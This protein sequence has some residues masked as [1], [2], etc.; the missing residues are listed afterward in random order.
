M[1]G[2][3]RWWARSPANMLAFMRE[4][5]A[6][7]GLDSRYAAVDVWVSQ[8][9][10]TYTLSGA[11][12]G[13][14]ARCAGSGFNRGRARPE[15]PPVIYSAV[16]DTALSDAG[17]NQLARSILVRLGRQPTA[18]DLPPPAFLDLRVPTPQERIGVRSPCRARAR[19]SG[20]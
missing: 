5:P 12:A 6:A 15:S 19:E 20:G 7:A 9:M 10:I 14:L 11:V 2:D 8:A 4:A 18:R 16:D 13:C 3:A 17:T 1:A